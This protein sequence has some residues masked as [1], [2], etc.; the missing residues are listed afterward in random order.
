MTGKEIHEA[1]LQHG[2]TPRTVEHRG[3]KRIALFFEVSEKIA[4]AVKNINDRKW[5]KTIGAWLIAVDKNLLI[6]LLNELN[7]NKPTTI[8]FWMDDYMRQLKIAAYSLNTQTT[9]RSA[10]LDFAFY[11]HGKDIAEL[12]KED[13]EKYLEH[14]IEEKKYSPSALNIAL[15]AI[16]F[17]YEKVWLNARKVYKIKRAKK[18]QQLP[19]VFGE[20][21]IKKILNAVENPK[22]KTMLS[23]SYAAG[24]RVS[25][26]TAMKIADIDSSRMV[27]NIRQAKGKK[28]RQVMMGDKLL[29]ILRHYAKEYKPK[30]W[31]FEGQYGEQYSDRSVQMVISAAKKKAGVNKKGSIHALR[32]SFATHLIEGGTD[33]FSIKELLGHTNIRTTTKYIHVSKKH[34]S[35]IQSPLDKLL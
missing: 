27:I 19:A 4:A 18:E 25:E 3:E 30:V 31:L 24:L 7:E 34:I 21:E 26:I 15:S 6:Q 29:E 23:L 11:Y 5:S 9:Y 1:L 17:L 14:L 13:I 16:K 32:H 12:S 8:P 22:H 20:S 35:K 2:I 33:I 10:I 28:D